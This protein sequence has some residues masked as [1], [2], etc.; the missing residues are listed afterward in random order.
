[1]AA[2]VEDEAQD[3]RLPKLLSYALAVA[4]RPSPRI[5]PHQPEQEEHGIWVVVSMVERESGAENLLL[6]EVAMTDLLLVFGTAA[7][8][9]E[10]LFDWTR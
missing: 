10:D 4:G 5:C 9:E 8:Q 7:G 2:V 3:W 6:K 1:M